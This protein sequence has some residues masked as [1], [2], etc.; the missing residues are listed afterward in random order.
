[1]NTQIEI[2]TPHKISQ[3]V[4]QPPRTVEII[5]PKPQRKPRLCLN[6]LGK[7]AVFAWLLFI[8]TTVTIIAPGG[9]LLA[10]G[11][12]AGA[13]VTAFAALVVWLSNGSREA[14]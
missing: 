6:G 8:V 5:Y 10:G 12:V 3:T 14:K 1:M 13:L 9:V 11:F 4:S 7:I 2:I